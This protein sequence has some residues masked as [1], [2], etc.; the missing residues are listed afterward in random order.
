M[1]KGR[2]LVTETA[3]LLITSRFYNCSSVIN[4][5]RCSPNATIA[6]FSFESNKIYLLRL[7]NTSTEGMQKFTIDEHN[8]TIITNDYVPIVP[9]QTQV[10]TLGVDQRTDVLVTTSED[11]HRSYNIRSNISS[12]Y[13]PPEQPH[14]IIIIYYPQANTS[15]FP[16][17]TAI[18][19]DMNHYVNVCIL[20]LF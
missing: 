8:M 6:T 3:V 12:I 1:A 10:I 7:I 17:S 5:T 20:T 2:S 14:I 13:N 11:P 4:R 18:T 16:T 15:L 19:Y 9:Y